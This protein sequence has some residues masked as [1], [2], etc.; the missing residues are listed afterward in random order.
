MSVHGV[1]ISSIAEIKR[2]AW[3]TVAR[4]LEL[5]AMKYAERFNL[6]M[7]KGFVIHEL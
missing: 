2:M 6:R 4:W 7:L 5:L 1:G 3:G